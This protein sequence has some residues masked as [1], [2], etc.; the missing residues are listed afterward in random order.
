MSQSN[1]RIE[2][3]K[4]LTIAQLRNEIQSLKKS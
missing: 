1:S 3:D 4:D 2:E